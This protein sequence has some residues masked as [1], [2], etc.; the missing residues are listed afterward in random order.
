MS[1]SPRHGAPGCPCEECLSARIE[2]TAAL[3]ADGRDM[4]GMRARLDAFRVRITAPAQA[5]RSAS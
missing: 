2:L 5:L 4:T 1:S 3:A